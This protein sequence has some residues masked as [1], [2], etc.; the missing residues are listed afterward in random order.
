MFVNKSTAVLAALLSLTS[1]SMNFMLMPFRHPAHYQ[2]HPAHRYDALPNP[3][4]FR[5]G[6]GA[7]LSCPLYNTTTLYPKSAKRIPR[8][9]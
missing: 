4:N 2:S 9:Q 1:H 6:Q 3:H 7:P 8:I 5:R